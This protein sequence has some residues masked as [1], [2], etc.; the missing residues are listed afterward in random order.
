MEVT[1]AHGGN[2]A[3]EAKALHQVE[4]MHEEAKGVVGYN[5]IIPLD[6]ALYFQQ[7]DTIWFF[8][9]Y[10][11]SAGRAQ[12]IN[13]YADNSSDR[14]F[15]YDN[16]EERWLDAGFLFPGMAFKVRALQ[17]NINWV[18]LEQP[19]GQLL[20][21]ETEDLVFAINSTDLEEND[22]EARLRI[23]S[24][25]P[26]LPISSV[27]LKLSVV[28]INGI[29]NNGQNELVLYPNPAHQFI[30][31]KLKSGETLTGLS[32]MSLNGKK[33]TIS[34]SDTNRI[35]LPQVHAGIYIV[36]V[37]TNKSTYQTKVMIE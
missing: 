8:L 12:A 17:Q 13:L 15:F 23:V 24:N 16:N 10:P 18:T 35:E 26:N 7:S 1:I 30:N 28:L 6:T 31:V 22:Y 21:N 37:R 20:A 14:Y 19:K 34:I 36:E 3:N 11:G 2:R 32:F 29:P 5:A 4:F 25:D 27:P 33:L 9:E